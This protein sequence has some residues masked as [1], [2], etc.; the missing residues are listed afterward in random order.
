MSAALSVAFWR[1][2]SA[3]PLRAM[4]RAYALCAPP[5]QRWASAASSCVCAA[6]G[7][8]ARDVRGV[9]QPAPTRSAARYPREEEIS[10]A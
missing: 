10:A 5:P 4:C 7:I 3:S 6:P 8:H 2:Q 9:R 1:M